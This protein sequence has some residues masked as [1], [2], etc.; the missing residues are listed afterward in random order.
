MDAFYKSLITEVI[1][2]FSDVIKINKKMRIKRTNQAISEIIGTMLILGISVSLFSVVYISVLTVPYS[3]PTPSVNIICQID[4]G[5]ITLSH[6]GGKA[7]NF[8][9]KIVLIVDGQPVDPMLAGDHLYN[10]SNGDGLWSAGE[11]VVFSYESL[12]SG[13]EQI[14]VNVLDIGS[15]SLVMTGIMEVP[16]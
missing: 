12:V 11:K 1:C 9:S 10:D 3:P 14:E 5:N 8:D 4:D 2:L 7:L 15:N 13:G 16:K 6:Y